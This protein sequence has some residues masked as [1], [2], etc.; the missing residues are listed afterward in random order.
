[1]SNELSGAEAV[2]KLISELRTSLPRY[3]VG[4]RCGRWARWAERRRAA[5]GR[6]C[7]L[8]RGN[9][10]APVTYMVYAHCPYGNVALSRTGEMVPLT[11]EIRSAGCERHKL[12]MHV[13]GTG[14]Q[15][16]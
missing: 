6:R 9:R 14:G 8:D 7:C 3:S 10:Q 16:P 11:K 12:I 2:Y 1:M 15:P 13:R 5:G 4:S